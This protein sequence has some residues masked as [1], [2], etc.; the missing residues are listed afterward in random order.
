M[1]SIRRAVVEDAESFVRAH[2][3]SWDA[4]IAPIVGHRLSELAP[5][6]DRV[7]RYRAGF[8]QAIP[9]AGVWVA[10][11]SG[12]VVGVAVRLDSELRDLY[13]VPEAWG[14]GIA[15]ALMDE[16]VDDIRAAGTTEAVLWVAEAN[17][18]ARRFYER[19]GWVLGTDSRASALGPR[20][21]QYCLPLS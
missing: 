5:F 7:A 17:G 20:E 12:T 18:R 19:S 16:A 13:V 3:A 9:N 1:F 6:E 2:E 21:V 11:Q 8:E 10:E 14:S 4:A 15:Q